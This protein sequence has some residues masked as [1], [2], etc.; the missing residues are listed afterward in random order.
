MCPR[1]YDA[2]VLRMLAE[3][4]RGSTAD[5]LDGRDPPAALLWT[6]RRQW[7]IHVS[8]PVLGTARP[9][10]LTLLTGNTVN[11]PRPQTHDALPRPGSQVDLPRPNQPR[12]GLNGNGARRN[13]ASH[14]GHWLNRVPAFVVKRLV[15]QE[16]VLGTQPSSC[17]CRLNTR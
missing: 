7:P 17:S 1:N 11:M 9:S 14:F 16:D 15:Q 3:A 13:P 8:H 6:R 2:L 12:P 5:S 10:S 4:A